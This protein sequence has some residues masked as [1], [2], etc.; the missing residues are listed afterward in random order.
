M[1]EY[2]K[3]Q[4]QQLLD[5]V[6]H[7]AKQVGAS[8]WAADVSESS[9]LSVN[10]RKGSVE[11]IEQTRDKGLSITVYSGLRRG[12][13]STSD[14]SPA[15]I[16][17]TVDA[18]YQI[19]RY[20]AE[21]AAASLP[22]A[23]LMATEHRDFDQYHPWDIGADDAVKLAKRMERAAFDVSP[24][25]ANSEGAS[26]SASHSHYL[27]ANSLG[28]VGGG[29]YSRHTLA[30]A[31]IA[32]QGD[33]M[34]RDD[35]YSSACALGKLASPERIGQYAAQRALAR[36][37]ARKLS[38]RKVPVLFEAPLACGLL[39]SLVQATSGGA[40]Y[41]R[42]SFLLDAMGKGIFPKHIDVVEDPFI[43]SEMGS[44][45]FDSEGVR[46]ARRELVSGGVLQGYFLSSYSARK[47]GMQTTGNAGGAHNLALTSRI[48][49]QGD[50]LPAM[51]KRMGSGLLVTDLMG[52]GVNYV[53]GDYSRGASGFWV[54]NGEIQYPVQEITI[55]GNL[56][57]MF[58]QI[59]AVGADVSLR[60]TKRTGSIL[61]E[62][63]AIAG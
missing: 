49:P 63:M 33:D 57:Q 4:F 32:G 37:K 39:G 38:T 19:A 45:S 52:Q 15:A 13:A 56:A 58:Q 47:L 28:F 55:A 54:H 20:T 10:V 51:L 34:Q 17:Q 50:D 26:V 14:F 12:H 6:A 61:I 5:Q 30:C 16:A 18:A 48:T 11:T 27:M 2:T 36:L 31:P 59:V 22:E 40:L 24:Q 41:R 3:N 1:F 25:I 29:P 60:G 43:P 42:S 23:E 44:G 21:D 35:W 9:G 62:Q 46:T 8:A 53:T 7:K